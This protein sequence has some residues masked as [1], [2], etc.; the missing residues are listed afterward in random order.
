MFLSI[1]YSIEMRSEN[2][3]QNLNCY[4]MEGETKFEDFWVIDVN[5]MLVSFFNTKDNKFQKFTITKLDKKTVAWNQMENALTV[6]V[7]DK[8][9]MRQSGTI[10]STVKD[11]Q[12]KIE[13]RWFSNCSFI[14]HDQLEN[15]I[16]VK[17]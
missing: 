7:L 14:S 9:T 6:F 5:K 15:F 2:S 4:H 11:G 10:I 8:T 17:Q 13:K 3:L 12:S 1:F 16:Q